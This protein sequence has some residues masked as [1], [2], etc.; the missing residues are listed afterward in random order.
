MSLKPCPKCG[1][2]VSIR[3]RAEYTNCHT[4]HLSCDACGLWWGRERV[5]GGTDTLRDAEE[6]F[7]RRWNRYAG[8]AT[9]GTRR[10]ET[11]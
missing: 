3:R 6:A 1:G 8:H 2:R 5:W 7:T 11:Q 10:E 9:A 4:L